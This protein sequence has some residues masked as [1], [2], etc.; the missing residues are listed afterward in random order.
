[1]KV[2]LPGFGKF[3]DSE[4]KIIGKIGST[5]SFIDVNDIISLQR[6]FRRKYYSILG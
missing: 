1:M 2:W 5:G 4:E 6:S 3:I